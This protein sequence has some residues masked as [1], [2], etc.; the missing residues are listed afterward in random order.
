MF[1]TIKETSDFLRDLA[2]SDTRIAIILGTGLGGLVNDIKIKRKI[3]YRDI[4]NFPVSTVAG[5]NGE[6]II[7]LLSGKPV[8][9]MQGRFHYYEGYSLKE[10]TFP[11]R[12]MHEM[13]INTLFVSNASGGLNPGFKVGDIMM[14]NDHINMF[15]SSPLIG[16]NLDELGP[17]FPDMINAYDPLLRKKAQQIA[18]AHGIELKEGIY[19]GVSG[20]T[21]ETPAEYKMYRLLGGDAIGMSTVPEVIVARHMRMRV[22]GISVITDSGVPGQ[23]VEVTHEKVQDVAKK[24][25]SKVSLIIKELIASI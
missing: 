6:L 3:N 23:I 11:V 21:Y 19:V 20:P 10:V 25:E 17:R 1:E 13:G 18:G 12:V 7:G 15:G 8:L 9:A 4:P 14:I 22:F 2:D 16:P 24:A 5:H